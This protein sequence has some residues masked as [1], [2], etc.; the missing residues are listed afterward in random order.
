MSPY[1]EKQWICML[2]HVG[3]AQNAVVGE[4]IVLYAKMQLLKETILRVL[5]RAL[6]WNHKPTMTME[7][8]F[9]LLQYEALCP[10]NHFRTED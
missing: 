8:N 5:C 2:A 6:F 10:R 9:F 7:A 1:F 4:E 3:S